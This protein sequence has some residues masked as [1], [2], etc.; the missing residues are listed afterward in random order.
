MEKAGWNYPKGET[1]TLIYIYL[2]YA[3]ITWIL[4]FI[5]ILFKLYNDTLS[6]NLLFL[7]SLSILIRIYVQSPS[8]LFKNSPL[9]T[10]TK[11]QLG[12]FFNLFFCLLKLAWCV[13]L[14]WKFS[15]L[16]HLVSKPVK[17]RKNPTPQ[18][19]H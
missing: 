16:T 6:D 4:I 12:P 1:N 11:K 8:P 19:C 18:Q 7:T 15:I 3:L 17:L 14:P 5:N 2:H 13:V 10:V 9:S